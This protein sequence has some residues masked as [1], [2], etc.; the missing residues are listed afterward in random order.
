MFFIRRGVVAA[1]KPVGRENRDLTRRGSTDKGGKTGADGK[2]DLPGGRS[3]DSGFVMSW[4]A[5]MRQFRDDFVLLG[6]FFGFY[7]G[8]N[9]SGRPLDDFKTFG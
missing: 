4:L 8:E 6:G 3:R 1:N 9:D 5:G 7:G 2:K